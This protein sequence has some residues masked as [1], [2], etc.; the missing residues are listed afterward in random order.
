MSGA[1]ERYCPPPATQKRVRRSPAYRAV[2]AAVMTDVM[3]RPV[4]VRIDKTRN[5][6]NGSG[7]PLTA[8]ID[9]TSISV[10]RGH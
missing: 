9:R 8:D 10:A 5:E 3:S 7:H 1:R 2:Q 4:R 6:H